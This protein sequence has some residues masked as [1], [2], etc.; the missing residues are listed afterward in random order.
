MLGPGWPAVLIHEAVGHGLEADA[1]RKST[2]VYKDSLGE[3][4][5][6]ECCTIID[7]ATVVNSR[8]S[9]NVDDEG[10]CVCLYDERSR[11]EWLLRFDIEI[12]RTN[13]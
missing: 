2:S 12:E 10:N 6:S 4:V 1:I 8:G 7:D 9:L 3:M 11:D 5:A 13:G